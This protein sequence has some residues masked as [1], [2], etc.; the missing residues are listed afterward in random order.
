MASNTIYVGPARPDI[1]RVLSDIH[2]ERSARRAALAETFG[3]RGYGHTQDRT[4]LVECEA[5]AIRD[6][7]SRVLGG[8][9]LSSVVQD[10]NRR[11]LV[12]TTGGPWRVNSLSALLIQPR[13]AGLHV[14]GGGAPV[15]KWP[16]IIDPATHERLVNLRSSRGMQRRSPRRSLLNGLLRCGRCAGNLHFLHR[17]DTNEYYRCPAPAAGGCSGVIVKARLAEDYVRDLVVARVDSPDF[18]ALADGSQT[19]ADGVRALAQQI[20]DDLTRLKELARLWGDRSITRSEWQL[21]RTD[22]AHRLEADEE[23][24]HQIES[25]RSVLRMAGEGRALAARWSGLPPGERREII[26]AVIDHVVVDPVGG[27]GGKFQPER[28]RPAWRTV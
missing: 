16:A 10:W 21:A 18:A 6:A 14:N 26:V 1:D 22:V 17:T 27:M 25:V 23:T 2:A 13:L 12:S 5:E 19:T 7:A 20:D 11:G 28:M 15:E 24:L 9:T 4:E 3:P 8:A